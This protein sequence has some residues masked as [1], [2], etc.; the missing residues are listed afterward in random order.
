[1]VWSLVT[2]GSSEPCPDDVARLKPWRA[3]SNGDERS[4]RVYIPKGL[5][6]YDKRGR[7]DRIRL[8]I[9]LA[10]HGYSGRPLQELRK[11]QGVA[12]EL[13]AVIIAPEG[14]AD[15]KRNKGWNAIDCCLGDDIVTTEDDVDFVTSAV[16][17]AVKKL[18]VLRVFLLPSHV[19][20]TGF[21]NGGFL[22]S[23]LALSDG[24]PSWLV[25]AV[26][27]GGYQYDPGLYEAA[28]SLS[29]MHH[30]GGSDSIVRPAGCCSSGGTGG[31]S[32]CPL[33]IGIKRGECTSVRG[34]F[35]LWAEANGCG[36]APPEGKEEELYSKLVGVDCDA[37]TELYVW[38]NAGHSWGA[39]FPG[40]DVAREWMSSV[41]VDAE[42]ESEEAPSSETLPSPPV[43]GTSGRRSFSYS[44]GLMGLVAVSVAFVRYRGSVSKRKNSDEV[45][46]AETL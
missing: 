26:P 32:N 44:V 24:R 35:E 27:T 16:D 11:W 19:I 40:V 42:M 4:F 38:T 31:G 21:S 20:A 5:C 8:R 37:S 30:H 36:P 43:R 28:A 9:I 22:T 23:L 7:T 29:V 17:L 18:R 6:E 12:D 15:G 34:A 46:M 1:M 39:T 45:Q 2:D 41:F 33:D 25:G 13:E 10:L 14:K 3:S